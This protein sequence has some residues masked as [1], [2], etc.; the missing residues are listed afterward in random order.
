MHRRDFIKLLL[1][2]SGAAL[3]AGCQTEAETATAETILIVGAGMAGI[4][5][6][7]TLHDAG[8]T[9]IVLEG[10]D[11]VGGRVWT[12]RH[13]ADTTLDMGASWIH[14][15]RG[16]PLTA[17]ADEIDAPRKATNS[18][19]FPLYDVEGTLAPDRVWG[20]IEQYNRQV[21]QAVQK[22]ARLDND[23]SIDD[24][25]MAEIDLDTLSAAQKRLLNVAVNAYYEQ[26]FAS[27]SGELSAH[28]VN[29]GD[30]FGGD[31]VVFPE[32]YDALVHHLATDLDIRLNEI[33]T[34]ISYNEAG[35]TVSTNSETFEANR[36]LVTLPLGV[37]K[38]G[39]VTFD[40]PLPA[41]KQQA[42]DVLGV[43]VLNK[44]YLQFSEPFWHRAPDW[45]TYISEEKGVFSAW[46]NIYRS[47]KQPV[48]LAF[49]A[50]T[51]GRK[52]E[53]FSDDEIVAQAMDTLRL[54]YGTNATDPLDAQITRWASDPFAFG[55]YSSPGVGMTSDTRSELAAPIAD[56]IFFAGEATHSK[57]PSTVH[58]AYLSGQREARR[59]REAVG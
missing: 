53:T 21:M 36:V 30:V 14:G 17:I 40:P 42:I 33:V 19:S 16:N 8:H 9:V 52:V 54:M 35:V 37:L 44:V 46:F 56:R 49:N 3:L 24:A 43:G 5:A 4:S 41:N 27:D 25:I 34:D 38:E 12:S 2:T 28:H 51:F 29:E 39:T 48:F 11:R 55:S 20:Q 6:A 32:G 13:W 10:R 59:I 1:A 57:Y 26:E 45:I 22:T 50:G 7:R 58:G 18:S 15:E 23:I 31:D 47:T